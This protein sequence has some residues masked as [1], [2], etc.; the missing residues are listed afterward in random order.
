VS[1]V[2]E[3]VELVGAKELK[4]LFAELPRRVVGKGLRAA[5][6]AG[7]T[8]VNRAAKAAAPRQSGL[9]KK[10]MGRKVKGYRGSAVAVIGARAAVQGAY[11]GRKR[12]PANYIHLVEGGARP[13]GIPISKGPAKGRIVRHPGS[14]GTHFLEAAYRGNKAAAESAMKAKLKET[15]ER[16]ALKLGK[17]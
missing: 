10:A 4:A 6:T 7:S 11:K 17:R 1:A 12:V 3:N 8:P 2:R 15:V 13:H 9:L 5:V 14:A 16:E